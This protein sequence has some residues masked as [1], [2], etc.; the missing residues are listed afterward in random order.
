MVDLSI[1]D[2]FKCYIFELTNNYKKCLD[3]FINHPKEDQQVKVFYWLK[4]I[5]TNIDSY[6]DKHPIDASEKRKWEQK[7]N[8]RESIL[9]IFKQNL[10]K[11]LNLNPLKAFDIYAHFFK[12][13]IFEVFDEVLQNDQ[14]SKLLLLERLIQ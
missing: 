7:L 14:E 5:I 12:D 2:E 4:K 6:L 3:I 9:L 1:Y 8:D 13:D 11:F 10:H